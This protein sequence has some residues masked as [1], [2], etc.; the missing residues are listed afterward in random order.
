MKTKFQKLAVTAVGFVLT[1]SI[2]K[3]HAADAAIMNWGLT[4]FDNSGTSVVGTGGFTYDPNITQVVYTIPSPPSPITPFVI[5]PTL[6]SVSLNVLGKNWG[7]GDSQGTLWWDPSQANS[8]KG[9]I[10]F[11]DGGGGLSNQWGF[12]NGTTGIPTLY[13][14]GGKLINGTGWG[15]SWMQQLSGY[16]HP[17]DGLWKATPLISPATVPE[18]STTLAISTLGL[19]NFWLKKLRASIK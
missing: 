13:M 6:L 15:G 7:N 8:T 5:E 17:I 11:H 1:A 16:Q 4:F 3:P 14:T 2:V 19:G 9:V 18:P 10:F 12:G